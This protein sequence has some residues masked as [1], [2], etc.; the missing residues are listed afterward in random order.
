MEASKLSY[1]F[2]KYERKSTGITYMVLPEHYNRTV[3]KNDVGC[4][5]R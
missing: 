3:Q 4:S 2:W 1:R 5:S